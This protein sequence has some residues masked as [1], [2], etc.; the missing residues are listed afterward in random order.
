MLTGVAAAELHTPLPSEGGGKETRVRWQMTKRVRGIIAITG[1]ERT[2]N[3]TCLGHSI[4]SQYSAMV[5]LL[6][7]SSL[8]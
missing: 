6:I 7:D 1:R 3:T 8:N 2:H 4:I 5:I